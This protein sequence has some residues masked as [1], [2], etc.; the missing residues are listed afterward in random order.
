MSSSLLPRIVERVDR[1]LARYA[2]LRTDRLLAHHAQLR[3]AN[4]LLQVQVQALTQERDSLQSRLTAARSR[5][6]ELLSHLARL[7]Q[8]A[9]R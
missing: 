6:E 7:G 5:N 9:P 2:Q 8:E 3:N 4:A 1:L